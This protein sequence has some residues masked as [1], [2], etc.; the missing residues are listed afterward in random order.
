MTTTFPFGRVRPIMLR[1]V[2][3]SLVVAAVVA[4]VSIATATFGETSWRLIA[5]AVLFT[6]FALFS[7]YDADVSS[8]RST[9]FALVSFAVSIYLF[10]AGMVKIWAPD[11]APA[12]PYAY[13]PWSAFDGFGGWLVVASIARVALLHVHLVLATGA[14]L[15]YP[16]MS[17]VTSVTLVLVATLAVLLTLPF[18]FTSLDPGEP[19]WRAVG[20]VAVLDALG[21]VLVP[22]GYQ[23]FAGPSGPAPG[24]A[25]ASVTA[26]GTAPASVSLT[27]PSSEGFRP[28]ATAYARPGQRMLQ[29]PRYDDGSF[30]PVASGGGPD[31]SGVVGYDD[32]A[33]QGPSR[34]D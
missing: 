8:K 11:R 13:E 27:G 26:S 21:T 31:F 10:V 9:P 14:R 23:L 28:P 16:V 34:S 15:R 24:P 30:L 22:L 18:L 3:A 12:D 25:P 6:A 1:V 20:V 19:Y 2:I 29:W 17:V 33:A 5:T 4:I 7:W 32:W